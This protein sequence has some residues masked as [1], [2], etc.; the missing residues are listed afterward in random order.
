MR[1]L[2]SDKCSVNGFKVKN[3]WFLVVV[4]WQSLA[5]RQDPWRKVSWVCGGWTW[6]NFFLK[7]D[8]PG[9]FRNLAGALIPSFRTCEAWMIILVWFWCVL[10]KKLQYGSGMERVGSQPGGTPR[11]AGSSKPTEYTEKQKHWK[12]CMR[13]LAETTGPCYQLIQSTHRSDT[14]TFVLT[15][16]RHTVGPLFTFWPILS[17]HNEHNTCNAPAHTC[18]S[19]GA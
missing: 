2:C 6:E 5:L 17:A 13:Q 7:H 19:T 14:R 9:R 15:F 11:K 10:L 18:T 4:W 1:S 3:L 8:A 16:H 12:E